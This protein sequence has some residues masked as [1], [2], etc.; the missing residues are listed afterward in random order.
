[1]RIVVQAS[2]FAVFRALAE[3]RW[4]VVVHARSS[5]ALAS[6]P[7]PELPGSEG[8]RSL[9]SGHG[10]TLERSRT[11][12]GTA[13]SPSALAQESWANV[14]DYSAAQHR[15]RS[16]PAGYR[17]ATSGAVRPECP[18]P[19]ALGARPHGHPHHASPS[20]PPAST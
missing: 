9:L 6:A 19:A 16:L 18:R 15:P 2:D 11:A 5:V 1:M 3:H 17:A 12:P 14:L 8:E 10:A 13:P 7:F 4:N 20:P